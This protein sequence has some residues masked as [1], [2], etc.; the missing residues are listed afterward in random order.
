M[1]RHSWIIGLA[2]ETSSLLNQGKRWDGHLENFA[3][4]TSPIILIRDNI[5]ENVGGELDAECHRRGVQSAF[6]CPYTPEQDQAEGYLGRVTTMASFAMVFSGAP[7]YMWIW[8]IQ[9]AV[10]LNNICATYYSK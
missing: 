6:I 5:A 2:M 1:D 10:F 8:C 7:L 3:A 4:G 9:C